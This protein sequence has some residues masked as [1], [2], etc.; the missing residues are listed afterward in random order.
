MMPHPPR[1]GKP[2][3][4]LVVDDS[5]VVRHLVSDALSRDPDIE[6]AGTAMDPYIA[7]D[8]IL[9]LQ[10]D[11]L[12][13]DLEMPRM[14]GLTFLRILM[15]EHPLP[16]VI[17]SSLT[18]QGSHQALDALRLGAVDVIGKPDGPFSFGE[19]G[20]QLVAKVKA[21]AHARVRRGDAGAL[22][23]G[24]SM[25]GAAGVPAKPATPP[26]PG[27]CAPPPPLPP[28]PGAAP[29]PVPAPGGP[30]VSV[31]P[32]PAPSPPPAAPLRYAGPA[33]S[34]RRLIVLG[35]STGGTEAL[36]QVL[37]RLPGG[38]PPVAIVQH[39]PATFSRAFAERLGK[40]C[41][42]EVREAVDGDLLLPGV[43]LVAPGNLHLLV[44][45]RPPGAAPAG[46]VWRV[47][48]VDGPRVWHQRPAVDLLFRSAAE[49]AGRHAI[50]GVLT[51][52]GKDGADGLLRLRRA[53]AVTFAQD[54]ASCIV[55]GMPRVAWE[56]GAAQ[57]QVALDDI[58]DFLLRA[59]ADG[60]PARAVT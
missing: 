29:V 16:V 7:R 18:Q 51:G 4:V 46:G 54:E 8:K 6:V 45:P 41:A 23:P 49:C 9:R 56:T 10:P 31:S 40:L 21:A 52:M 43:A 11:V 50:A 12:T 25:F 27:R 5:A 36:R 39:I 17:M 44:E 26:D 3:R 28:G 38:L 14:D 59:V 42:F 1:P 22:R 35:A 48:V 13:L 20:S 32:L 34:P 33:P 30:V 19:L 47:R 24:E 37:T 58:P 2:V 55:Y 57:R 53:G 15:A 60:A